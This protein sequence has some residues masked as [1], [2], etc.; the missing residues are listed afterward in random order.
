M[1]WLR[2]VVLLVGVLDVAVLGLVI[3]AYLWVLGAPEPTPTSG[4]PEWQHPTRVALLS[5]LAAGTAT[6][7]IITG[8]RLVRAPDWRVRRFATY[9]LSSV[10]LMAA[11]L[12]ISFDPSAWIA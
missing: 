6:I 11:G 12:V 7:A 5:V 4:G 8:S 9:V 2:P 10:A 3:W 1:K